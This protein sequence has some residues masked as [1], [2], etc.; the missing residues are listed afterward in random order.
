MTG[1]SG[2]VNYLTFTE[3]LLLALKSIA[4]GFGYER[5]RCVFEDDPAKLHKAFLEAKEEFGDALPELKELH[6]SK[7]GFFPYSHELSAAKSILRMAGVIEPLS[8][9]ENAFD[10]LL[11]KDSREVVAE[12]KRKFLGDDRERQSAFAD[13]TAFLKSRLLRDAIA[14]IKVY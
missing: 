10:V 6:F 1:Y 13:F 8:T 2:G 4:L 14:E 3:L 9:Q 12:K 7:K 11:K 5:V